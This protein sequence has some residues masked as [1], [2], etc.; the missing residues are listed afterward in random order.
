MNQ[1]T[2]NFKTRFVFN[3]SLELLTKSKYK[4]YVSLYSISISIYNIAYTKKKNVT[5]IESF[6]TG[7]KL[8]T[9]HTVRTSTAYYNLLF[10]SLYTLK[11]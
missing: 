10:S 8:H 7:Y 2:V 5:S 3:N 6:K 11:I 1:Q 4:L 9:K